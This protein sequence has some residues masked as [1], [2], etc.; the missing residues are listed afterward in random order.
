MFIWAHRGASGI[1]PENTLQ[2]FEQAIEAGADGIELDVQ[3]VEDVPI[4]LH[5][6]WLQKTTN[7]LGLVR[8]STLEYV[9]SLDAGNGQAVPSLQQAL[10]AIAGRCQVNIEI[11]APN[12]AALVAR[13]IQLA[14]DNAWFK[15]EQLIVSSFDHKQLH[16]FASLMPNIRI[17]AL[18]AC[19][20]TDNSR[21]AVEL[22]AWSLHCNRDFIDIELVKDAQAQGLKVY[23]YTV[24]H[25]EDIALMQ[26]L[27][28]D[29]IF[30]DYPARALQ[31]FKANCQ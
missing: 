11:K 16:Q 13:D 3:I 29:G 6:A 20:P 19:L 27:G 9:Q 12:S 1:A 21:F 17:G 25:V 4:V 14:L 26:S 15:P 31:Y 5:D 7:G 23:V 24:N 18:T 30:T 28:V 22:K 10:A 2:A 8:S